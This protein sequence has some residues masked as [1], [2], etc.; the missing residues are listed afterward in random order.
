MLN[1]LNNLSSSFLGIMLKNKTQFLMITCIIIFYCTLLYTICNQVLYLY[2]SWKWGRGQ[3]S[4][5]LIGLSHLLVK[6]QN[7][8]QGSCTFQIYS[9]NRQL[10]RQMTHLMINCLRCLQALSFSPTAM[11]TKNGTVF[12]QR[13][14]GIITS[15]ATVVILKISKT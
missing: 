2:Y 8:R 9:L 7:P 13:T 12:L 11:K 1:L 3:I 5:Q 10:C 6:G 15:V 14:L 4:P